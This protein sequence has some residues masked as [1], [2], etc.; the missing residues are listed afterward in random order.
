MGLGSALGLVG[1]LL[2][3]LGGDYVSLPVLAFCPFWKVESLSKVLSTYEKV[4]L[5]LP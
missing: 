2:L 3:L 5:S 4:V 1:S